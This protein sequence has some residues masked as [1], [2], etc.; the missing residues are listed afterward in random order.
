LNIQSLSSGTFV[1]VLQM[2][3]EILDKGAAHAKTKGTDP[4]SLLDV[5]LAAGHASTQLPGEDC[6]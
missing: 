4:N 2:L 3:S 5:R 1:P 6:L